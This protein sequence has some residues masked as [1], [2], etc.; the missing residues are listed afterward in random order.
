[1]AFTFSSEE[2]IKL[3]NIVKTP[4]KIA[5]NSTL[6]FSLFLYGFKAICI[7]PVEK[8]I[9]AEAINFILFGSKREARTS[10]FLSVFTNSQ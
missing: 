1:M 4:A 9:K 5:K 8:R 10:D 3:D 7:L 2:N 6:L